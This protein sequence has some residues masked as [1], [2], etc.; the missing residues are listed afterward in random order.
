MKGVSPPGLSNDTMLENEDEVK[1]GQFNAINN[2][3]AETVSPEQMVFHFFVI[4]LNFL[5]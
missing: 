3:R 2:A 4:K 1:E 5:I